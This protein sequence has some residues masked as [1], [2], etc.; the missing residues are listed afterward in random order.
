V[1]GVCSFD[2]YPVL[3]LGFPWSDGPL[4]GIEC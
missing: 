4:Q 1:S 3:L 2:P